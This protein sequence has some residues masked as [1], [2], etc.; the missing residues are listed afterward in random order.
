MARRSRDDSALGLLFQVLTEVFS[1]VPAWVC[2]PFAAIAWGAIYFFVG[3]RE[4]P[5][6][7]QLIAN[8]LGSIL[9]LTCLAAGLAGWKIQRKRR[10]FLDAQIDWNW[11]RNLSW[12]EFEEHVA[13]VYRN[14]GYAAELLGGSR[15]D[16]GVDIKLKKDD[17]VTLV[18]CKHWKAW[19]VGVKTARELFGVI[20]AERA[21]AGILIT[22]GKF[23]DEAK[24]FASGKAM[25]LVEEEEFIRL[26]C[27][28]QRDLR[29]ENKEKPISMQSH[30]PFCPQCGSAMVLRTAKKGANAGNTFWGC[31][32]FPKCRGIREVD[33]ATKPMPISS[34]K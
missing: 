2:I 5:I 6:P 34:R 28:F 16:G 20:S 23:T 10:Q 32:T 19:K 25:E 27:E 11:V 3:R 8:C 18:Q 26:V 13:E 12:R 4:G 22:S 9:A 24:R 1:V 17:Q 7:F 33:A 31:M 15:P 29:G 14:R 21:H 30:A